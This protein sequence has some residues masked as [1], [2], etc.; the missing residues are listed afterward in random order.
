MVDATIFA[1]PDARSG[2]SVPLPLA[3][4]PLRDSSASVRFASAE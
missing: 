1:R 4:K 3:E 2:V